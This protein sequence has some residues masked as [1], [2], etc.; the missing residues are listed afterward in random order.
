MIETAEAKPRC[1]T[2]LSAWPPSLSL[3]AEEDLKGD[4]VR[5]AP[6]AEVGK[7]WRRKPLNSLIPRL[8]TATIRAAPIL[9][10]AFVQRGTSS[11]RVG[12]VVESDFRLQR[13]FE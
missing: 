7:K 11:V 9:A 10:N 4:P 13:L 1:P 5:R 12:R 2:V 3:G 6:R 8:E